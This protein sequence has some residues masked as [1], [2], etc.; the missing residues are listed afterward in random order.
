MKNKALVFVSLFIMSSMC[1]FAQTLNEFNQLAP[2]FSDLLI[3][4]LTQTSLKGDIRSIV[5]ITGEGEERSGEVSF[6]D[7]NKAELMVFS[8]DEKGNLLYGSDFGKIGEDRMLQYKMVFS[9]DNKNRLL[10]IDNYDS[11]GERLKSWQY[12]YDQ[13]NVLSSIKVDNI[14]EVGYTKYGVDKNGSI[15]NIRE[16]DDSGNLTNAVNIEKRYTYFSNGK[17]K[18][19]VSY[20]SDQLWKSK[21]LDD[22]GRIVEEI[23]YEDGVWSEKCKYSY[24][25]KGFLSTFE[26]TSI[27]SGSQGVVSYSST[28]DNQGNIIKSYM[29]DAS[30]GF[31]LTIFEIDYW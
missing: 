3:Y 22:L 29:S 20:I 10:R 26:K 27:V 1:T 11:T 8:F 7:Y 5:V 16:Y 21:T 24:D 9:Y 2:K 23:S 30:T 19:V 31:Y 6:K 17:L 25:S 13:N 4:K 12:E 28:Y 18:A 14:Y 15:L